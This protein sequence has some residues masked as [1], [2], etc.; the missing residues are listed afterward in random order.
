MLLHTSQEDTKTE[1]AQ[2]HSGTSATTVQQSDRTHDLAA[3]N[4]VVEESQI[5]SFQSFVHDSIPTHSTLT[6]HEERT[7]ESVSQKTRSLMDLLSSKPSDNSAAD[8]KAS[9]DDFHSNDTFCLYYMY[10]ACI[11]IEEEKTPPR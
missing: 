2:A 7:Q 1:L 6:L 3:D 5:R 4:S 8:E 10:I 11:S 9:I